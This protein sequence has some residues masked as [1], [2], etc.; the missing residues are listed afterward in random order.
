MKCNIQFKSCAL[1]LNIS[2]CKE[3]ITDAAWDVLSRVLCNDESILNTYQ[4]NHTQQ[5]LHDDDE[6]LP[7]DLVSL[8]KINREHE[9][10]QAARIKIIH[11]HFYHGFISYP[12]VDMDLNVLP[13][14]ALA[15]M[16]RDCEGDQVNFPFYRFPRSS[17]I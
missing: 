17:L 13:Y 1:E 14:Y 11:H 8:L 6:D 16:S 4:S 7:T 15:W 12:F 2:N 3:N 9:E 10:R 5:I